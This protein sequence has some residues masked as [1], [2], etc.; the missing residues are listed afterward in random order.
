MPGWLAVPRD[1][2]TSLGEIASFCGRMMG[3]VYSGRVL[4][5]SARRFARRGS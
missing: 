1:W 4:P 5:S 3:L 2:I